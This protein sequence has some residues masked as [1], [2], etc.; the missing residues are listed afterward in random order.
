MPFTT[1]HGDIT[2]QHVDAIVNAA[3]NALLQGGGV[4][5][6]I[7]RAA[8]ER[9]LA[10]ACARIGRCDTGEAV[11]TEGFRLP[12]KYVIHTVGPVWRGG[13]AG[14]EAMLRACYRNSLALARSLGLSSIAFP[15]ISSGIFGY[16]REQAL[17]VAESEISA[18]LET[19]EMEVLLVR[20][21]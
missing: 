1:I 3:N 20:Y 10:E 14:E 7:F 13:G 4:C 15:L 21:P 12:A 6:A 19:N 9:E 2:T 18:F 16:P 5:G 8:G 17:S 11:V